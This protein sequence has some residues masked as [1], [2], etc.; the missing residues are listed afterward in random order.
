M[1]ANVKLDIEDGME[2]EPIILETEADNR[3]RRTK[4]FKIR[5]KG[6]Q[7]PNCEGC[8][9]AISGGQARGHTDKRRERF[10]KIFIKNEE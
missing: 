2:D 8:K 5:K 6:F 1:K 3:E 4:S 7:T 9:R 10:V